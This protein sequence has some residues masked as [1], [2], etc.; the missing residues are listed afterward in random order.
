MILTKTGPGAQCESVK[1]CRQRYQLA[2]GLKYSRFYKV[3]VQLISAETGCND[4]AKYSQNDF[5]MIERNEL[6][7]T[8]SKVDDPTIRITSSLDC[9]MFRESEFKIERDNST[10]LNV[11]DVIGNVKVILNNWNKN[12]HDAFRLK[13][14]KT[15]EQWT[16]VVSDLMNLRSRRTE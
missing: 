5:K 11:G 3:Y 14:K 15:K 4:P 2:N 12:G 7:F 10:E 8:Y 1:S 13:R 6:I 9:A 16:V